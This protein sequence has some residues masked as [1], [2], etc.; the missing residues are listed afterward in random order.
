M[1]SQYK[2]LNAYFMETGTCPDMSARNLMTQ[3]GTETMKNFEYRTNGGKF[4]TPDNMSGVAGSILVSDPNG[5]RLVNLPN[6][7]EVPRLR[8]LLRVGIPGQVNGVVYY[9][10]GYTDFN[11]WNTHSKDFDPNM[12]LYI[13]SVQQ[14]S[15]A[16][17]PGPQG[18]EPYV[19]VIECTH[20]IHPQ[21][22]GAGGP[23]PWQTQFDPA[24]M[25]VVNQPSS[26]RP[27]DLM[28]SLATHQM[29]VNSGLGVPTIDSRPSIDLMKVDRRNTVASNYLSKAVEGLAVGYGNAGDNL[30]GAHSGTA[31]ESAA[32][33]TAELNPFSDRFLNPMITE[34]GLQQNGFISWAQMAAIHPELHMAGVTKMNTRAGAQ[35]TDAFVSDRSNF[36]SMVGDRRP[37][38]DFY[39]RVM[40]SLPGVMLTSL[41]VFGRIHV[42]NMT[43]D[44]STQCFLNDPIS[45]VDIPPGFLIGRIP[46]LQEK[47]KSLIFN[48]IGLPPHLPFDAHFT[49]DAF[50]ES[51]GSISIN[52]E[53][54]VPYTAASYADSTA[55]QLVSANGNVLPAMANDINFLV[56]H[57]C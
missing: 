24:Q 42:T 34:L 32:G 28:N 36:D 30:A 44:G 2:I 26:L 46:F 12:R 33:M 41:V 17:R 19:Q 45:F 8:F 57:I 52:C 53:Q 15:M 39:N 31:Y 35:A 49:I 1:N 23:S 21:N 7:F 6:G 22:L 47:F 3:I 38:T 56:T 5:E 51:F 27:Y 43:A 9:Y 55:S 4:L 25:G 48:D 40:A 10:E 50:G 20:L 29:T 14:V 54:A 16:Q 13:N 18:M 37:T 11:G